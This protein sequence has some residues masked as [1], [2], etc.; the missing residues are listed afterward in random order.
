MD[1]ELEICETTDSF[2]CEDYKEEEPK[3]CELDQAKTYKGLIGIYVDESYI[4]YIDGIRGELYYRGYPLQDLVNNS[5]FEEVAY[6][7]I[8]GKLPSKLE[9]KAFNDEMI[10]ERN[11]PEKFFNNF[12]KLSKKYY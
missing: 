10:K 1:R 6:L 3:M 9:L 12:K 11:I 5:S 8:Y 2:A 7:L 4:T